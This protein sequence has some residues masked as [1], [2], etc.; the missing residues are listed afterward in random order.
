[1]PKRTV[2]LGSKIL[3]ATFANHWAVKIG[4]TWYEVD[5]AG[6][7][8]NNSKNNISTKV[9]GSTSKNG[10]KL[11]EG[12]IVGTSDKTDKEIQKFIETWISN[13]PTYD[14]WT[15][16]CQKFVTDIT[17]WATNGACKLPPMEAGDGAHGYGPSAF[18]GAKNGEATAH[19]GTGHAEA[20][21]GVFR[22]SADGP[23]AG[24]SAM[25]GETGFGA[26]GEASLGKVEVSAGP[27]R[28]HLEPNIN[29]GV[30]MR[31]G[32]VEATFLGT[33]FKVGKNGV[34]VRTPLGGADCSIM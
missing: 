8:A 15:A 21:G 30:G 22:V 34:G 33:G 18:A 14:V 12:G 25:A 19:A 3:V 24:A 9:G 11:L 31:N 10:A 29:T 5:G 4:D 28:A 1:M 7:N 17:V 27:V 13:N 26:F 20:Q 2:Q 32:N 23:A 6:K 16:N